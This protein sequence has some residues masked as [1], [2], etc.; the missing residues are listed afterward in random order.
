MQ[1]GRRWLRAGLA[2]A[3]SA[4]ATGLAKGA[5]AQHEPTEPIRVEYRAPASCPDADSFTARMRARTDRPRPAAAGEAA[6]TFVVSITTTGPSFA[7]R[8]L[9]RDPDGAEGSRTVRGATCDEVVEALAL[10]AALAVDPLASTSPRPIPPAPRPTPRAVS[11]GAPEPRPPT[12]TPAPGESRWVWSAGADAEIATG[13]APTPLASVAV[14]LAVER[15]RQGAWSPAVRLALGGTRDSLLGADQTLTSYAWA[16]A[17]LSMTPTEWAPAEVLAI[18]PWISI[19]GGVVDAA[20]RAVHDAQ[21]QVVPWAALEISG[22]IT[23]RFVPGIFLRAEA[24]IVTTLHRYR[25][26]LGPDSTLYVE[27]PLGA[28][29]GVGLSVAL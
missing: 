1:L 28:R 14:L 3:S 2:L 19:E 11:S 13:V 23:Y 8:L 26:Y 20:G 27:P 12:R 24:G 17:A 7:G 18:R 9:I 21:E 16:H 10:F 6:R 4:A 5:S 25:F 15:E 29:A 22:E